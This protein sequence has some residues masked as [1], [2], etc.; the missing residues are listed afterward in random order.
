MINNMSRIW[1]AR[2]ALTLCDRAGTQCPAGGRMGR[3]TRLSRVGER[4]KSLRFRLGRKR[5]SSR[6]WWEGLGRGTDDSS[7]DCSASTSRHWGQ[8]RFCRRSQ[9]SNL[10]SQRRQVVGPAYDVA[11]GGLLLGP[12]F[13]NVLS[14]SWH[15]LGWM[16]Q[17]LALAAVSTNTAAD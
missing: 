13:M 3:G 5:Y 15:R 2:G 7:G 1:R 9:L 8:R 16:G 11:S 17:A 6:N 4:A 12:F 14:G 10:A